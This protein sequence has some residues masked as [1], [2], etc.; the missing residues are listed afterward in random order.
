[1][2]KSAK[3][4]KP[5]VLKSEQPHQS[6]PPP[7]IGDNSPDREAFHYHLGEVEKKQAFVAVA[8]KQLKE[9]RRRAQDAGI[10]LHDLDTVM[11][12]REEEPETVQEGI[13]RLATYAHWA[14]LAP[15]VQADLFS[16]AAA[17]QDA[18]VVAEEEGYIDGLEGKTAEGP[19]YD[20]TN[21]T[22]QA[23]LRGWNRG[24]GVIQDRFLKKNAEAADKAEAEG[25]KH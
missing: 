9:A 23:R 11:K 20:T 1:M 14:G 10:V 7:G 21:P 22:G 3:A 5:R 2:V 17:K 24:Q 18:E 15:G 19:R 8:R 12:M 6:A 25:T 16:H 4:Q 13:K